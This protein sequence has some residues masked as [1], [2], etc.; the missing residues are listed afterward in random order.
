[1]PTSNASSPKLPLQKRL[2]FK[3]LL[4]FLGTFLVV[5]FVGAVY[6][7]FSQ[8]R[9]KSNAEATMA[10]Q[11]EPIV[12]DPKL[13]SELAKVMSYDAEPND[14]AVTDPFIDRT[15]I[16]NS[17]M[18]TGGRIVATQAS[19][20][21]TAGSTAA[22]T[23]GRITTGG[24]QVTTGGTSTL[25][26][27]SESTKERYD[28][29]NK[30]RLYAQEIPPPGIFSVEDLVPVGVVS[31]GRGADEVMLLSLSLCQT[32]SYP[33]GTEFYDGYL[34]GM[35]REAVMFNLKKVM[36]TVTKSYTTAAPC[37]NKQDSQ[38]ATTEPEKS[39]GY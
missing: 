2:S 17:A 29:W 37:E 11:P 24:T 23:G 15:G 36:R 4:L 8:F 21:G 9:D 35:T 6:D 19:A 33:V 13:Q 12:I 16:S 27:A 26:P 39:P 7:V 14:V 22:T 20:S 31:G 5:F 18:A 38:V 25:S 3:L 32:V 10:A 1:M 34:T 30:N 28:A